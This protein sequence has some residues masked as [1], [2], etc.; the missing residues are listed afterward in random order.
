MK[1][2]HP[3]MKAEHECMT[4]IVTALDKLHKYH[5]QGDNDSV[6][7]ANG[8]RAKY[9]VLKWVVNYFVRDGYIVQ[10]GSK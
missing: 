6:A 8:V 10:G 7:E 4:A 3:D 5:Y 1:V 9:R 2:E